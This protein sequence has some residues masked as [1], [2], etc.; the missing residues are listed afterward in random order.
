MGLS[1]TPDSDDPQNVFPKHVHAVS[2]G[3]KLRV[4][5]L[6]QKISHPAKLTWLAPTQP[7]RLVAEYLTFTDENNITH[8]FLLDRW[9]VSEDL[10]T[11]TLVL[12]KGIFFNNGH[13]FTADDVIFSFNQWLDPQLNTA[14]SGIFGS[15]LDTT[16]IEKIDNHIVRL[17]LKRPEIALPEHLVHFSAMVLNHRT[18]EGDFLMA[19]HGTGPFTLELFEENNRCVFKKRLDYWQPGLPFL[20]QVEYKDL[21]HTVSRRVSCLLYTSDAA[22]DL[23]PV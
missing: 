9:H 10:K 20:D 8:P 17:H 15:Y 3:G 5:G 14:V 18:F 11:W 2:Y 22:D 21:G 23:Q 16:G 4:S 7:F 13:P 1:T 19:P 12:K 6:I